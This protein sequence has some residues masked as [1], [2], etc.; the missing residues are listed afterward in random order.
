MKPASPRR[1]GLGRAL[2]IGLPYLWLLLFF[3]VPFAI[4][5]KLSLSEV[6][7]AQ[8]P[9]LPLAQLLDEAGT[10]VLELRLNISNYLLLIQDSL[11]TRAYLNSVRIAALSTAMALVIGF[12]IALAVARASP[13]W[14]HR[15]TRASRA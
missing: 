10:F 6:A 4:V 8:P 9:Y 13:R 1:S 11:Y 12:P 15:R 2:L 5:L 3:L 7:M 14:R